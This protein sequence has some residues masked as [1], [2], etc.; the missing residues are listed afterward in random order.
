MIYQTAKLQKSRIIFRFI[1]KIKRNKK[2]DL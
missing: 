2:A 1:D